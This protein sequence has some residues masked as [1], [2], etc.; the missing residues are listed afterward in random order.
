MKK[1]L[2]ACFLFLIPFVASAIQFIPADKAFTLTVTPKDTQTLTAEFQI[3][4]GYHL[5]RDKISFS[6]D[7]ANAAKIANFNLPDGIIKNDKLLGTLDIYQ[8]NVD[9]AIPLSNVTQKQFTLIA[10]YQ[11]CADSGFCYPPVTKQ[12]AVNLENAPTASASSVTTPTA[13]TTSSSPNNAVTTTN[14]S[15]TNN[16][17]TAQDKMTALLTNSNWLFSLLAF[18]GFG[19]LLAFTPCILPMIPILSSIIV[20]QDGEITTQRAFVLSLIYVLAMALTY[21]IA[22]VVAGLAGSYVQAMLQSPAVIASFSVVFVLLALSLFGFYE[23]RMPHSWHHHVT[24]ISNKQSGGDYIGVAIMGCL[25]T[26]IVSPCVT[27]PLIGALGYIGKTGDAF[28]GGLAL[29][30]LGLGMGI[31]LLIIGTLGGKFL[32]KA[33]GWMDT[34]KIFFGVL[35]LGVAILLLSRIIPGE[36]TMLLW[37]GL[38]IISSVYMGAFTTVPSTNYGKLWKGVSLIMLVYG[39]LLMFGA[40]MGNADPLEPLALKQNFPVTNLTQPAGVFKIIKSS[41]DLQHELAAAQ[42]QNKPVILD[43]YAD[44][45]VSCKAMDR[46]TFKDSRVQ[47]L[48]NQFVLLRSD[49]T[50]NDA[51]DK[52]LEKQLGVIAP[53]SILFFDS[54]NEIKSLRVFG[55]TGPKPFANTLQTVLGKTGK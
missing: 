45:C 44:W 40:A 26:L 32:P 42:A 51:T 52:A 43:F 11:G 13:T 35:M 9:F 22:G 3:A 28:F 30:T 6:V 15:A 4:H 12:I 25:S 49:V 54:G 29:F 36:I 50:K 14:G 2:F 16:N 17:L 10:N 27:A 33:G 23:L 7:P 31:P 24:N 5:Y 41:A 19:V 1:L 18:F 38:L 20:G 47:P 48:M 53:P 46:N 37:A 21:S 55:E 39:F 34:V 8:N